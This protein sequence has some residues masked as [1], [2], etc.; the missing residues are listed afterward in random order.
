MFLIGFQLG[1]LTYKKETLTVTQEIVKN[2]KI[3]KISNDYRNFE[4]LKNGFADGKT[5]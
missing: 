2:E 3:I 1:N 4:R 5:Q